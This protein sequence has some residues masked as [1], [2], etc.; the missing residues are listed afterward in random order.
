MNDKFDLE[1]VT[2]EFKS[3]GCKLIEA[4]HIT[5]EVKNNFFVI[6]KDG[7][8]LIFRDEEARNFYLDGE[9][10]E[11]VANFNLACGANYMADIHFLTFKKTSKGILVGYTCGKKQ[12]ID[13]LRVNVEK[14]NGYYC[15]F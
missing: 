4:E 2:R 7:T 11:E 12:E 5:Q 6:R 15:K 14:A 10:A 8:W 1:R 13:E 3:S 9:Y